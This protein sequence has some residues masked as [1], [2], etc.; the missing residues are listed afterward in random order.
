[1]NAALSTDFSSD[2]IDIYYIPSNIID[3]NNLG[4]WLKG[5]NKIG[6]YHPYHLENFGSKEDL[7]QYVQIDIIKQITF[8]QLYSTYNIHRVNC[9]KLDTEGFDC[10]I[11]QQLLSFL[12]D[13]PNTYYP[14]KIIFESNFLT[15]LQFIYQ[16]IEDYMD[17]G[18]QLESMMHGVGGGN[19]ILTY[20]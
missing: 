11:L 6:S 3:E 8:E 7:T 16:T 5:C 10:H 4:F 1:M 15:N 14:S 17:I 18:Y 12:K 9:M 2:D 13:K 19:A 20:E